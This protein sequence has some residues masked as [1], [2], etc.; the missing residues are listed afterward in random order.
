[1]INGLIWFLTAQ[2]Y[3][4]IMLLQYQNYPIWPVRFA[5]VCNQTGPIRQLNSQWKSSYECQC[6]VANNKIM[7]EQVFQVDPEKKNE[8]NL[9]SAIYSDIFLFRLQ[10]SSNTINLESVELK[11]TVHLLKSHEKDHVVVKF[12]K[13]TWPWNS[14]IHGSYNF[15]ETKW[16]DF[17]RT[18]YSF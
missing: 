1:M 5:G 2:I 11:K 10:Q 6:Q 3:C 8:F 7:S 17:S 4:L 18:N 16:N 12:W 13:V 15:R 9:S 14:D